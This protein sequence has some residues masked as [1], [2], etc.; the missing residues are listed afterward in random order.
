MGNTRVG[1]RATEKRS[2]LLVLG[3]KIIRGTEQ[4]NH[5]RP[6][7]LEKP[8]FVDVVILQ[9]GVALMKT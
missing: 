4:E 5:S 1:A 8:G 2:P 6:P 9:P 7:F 3:E